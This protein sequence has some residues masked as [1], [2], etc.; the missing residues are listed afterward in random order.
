[1]IVAIHTHLACH[2]GL[3]IVVVPCGVVAIVQDI[4]HK[5][6]SVFY[7]LVKRCLTVDPRR[8]IKAREAINH[9]FF[10]AIRGF[11]RPTEP[12][13]RVSDKFQY[14]VDVDGVLAEA[15]T[16]SGRPASPRDDHS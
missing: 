2:H 9:T 14:R 4:I 5:D 8:R 7:D 1:V 12:A 13:F 11:R 15:A 6:D 3:V 10:T 16:A